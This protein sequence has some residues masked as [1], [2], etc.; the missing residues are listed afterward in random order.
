MKISPATKSCSSAGGKSPD[1]SSYLGSLK[2]SVSVY[3]SS[4]ASTENIN[5]KPENNDPEPRKAPLT[6][7][8]VVAQSCVDLME[9]ESPR[10][11][12][13]FPKRFSFLTQESP[14]KD[15]SGTEIRTSELQ[16]FVPDPA[17]GRSSDRDQ[18]QEPW[19]G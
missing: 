16:I 1:A 12:R 4:S 5:K 19:E 18:E 15:P 2:D 14:R 17:S 8:T 9:A 10:S 13:S 11:S 3:C 6:S 7:R